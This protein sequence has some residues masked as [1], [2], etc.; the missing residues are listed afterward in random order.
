MYVTK[1]NIVLLVLLQ[2]MI[3]IYANITPKPVHKDKKDKKLSHLIYFKNILEVHYKP[4]KAL[5][6]V[7]CQIIFSFIEMV[8]VI[9]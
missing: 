5:T 4:I 9:Q 8:L 1:E 2:L 3:H 7:N 6:T